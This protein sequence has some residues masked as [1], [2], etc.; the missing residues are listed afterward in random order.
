MRRSELETKYFKL[1]TNDTLKA[2][3]KQKNYC[4]R[5]YK[6]EKNSSLEIW[7]S[8]VVDNTKFWKVAKPLFN[9]KGSEVSNEVVL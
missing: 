6:K 7:M 4:S 8:F 3:K 9:E 2:Y 5:L 1:K